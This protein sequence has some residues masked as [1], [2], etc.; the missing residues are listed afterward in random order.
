M[1]F[2]DL[3]VRELVWAMHSIPSSLADVDCSCCVLDVSAKAALD[4]AN[5]TSAPPSS[6]TCEAEV[7]GVPRLPIFAFS[8][9]GPRVKA[10]MD[11]AFRAYDDFR[12]LTAL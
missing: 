4:R 9:L 7:N 12:M 11:A 5:I 6:A 3:Q 1:V 2:L 10:S 8:A